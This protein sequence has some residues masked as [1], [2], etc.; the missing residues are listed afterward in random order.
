M[1]TTEPAPPP[2][3]PDGRYVLIKGRRWRAT[4]PELPADVAD[5]LRHH[6]MAAR[7]AVGAALRA[8][9]AAAERAARARVQSAKVALGERGTPWWEQTD[10][11]RRHRWETGLAELDAGTDPAS[12]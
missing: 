11:E 7:R 3:T 12:R 4:D 2:H 1:S 5:R 10:E 8:E 6:L 9:D